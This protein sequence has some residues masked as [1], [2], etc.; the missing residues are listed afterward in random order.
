M[1][2]G[3]GK[4]CERQKEKRR[5]KIHALANFKLKLSKPKE[6]ECKEVEGGQSIYV[7]QRVEE[8]RPRTSGRDGSE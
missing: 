6:F 7:I 4:E 5:V 3:S 2:D 8:S 1:I